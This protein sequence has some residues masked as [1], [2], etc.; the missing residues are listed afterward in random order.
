MDPVRSTVLDLLERGLI[1]VIYG[2]T[3][4]AAHRAGTGLDDPALLLVAASNLVVVVF[5]VL[6]PRPGRISE[7]P[8]D[9]LIAVIGTT[10]PMFAVP[11]AGPALLPVLA[12]MTLTVLG[13]GVSFA[14]KLTLRRNFSIV[15]ART[16]IVA[17]GV[18]RLVRHPMYSGYLLLQLGILTFGFEPRNLVCFAVCWWMLW[19]RMGREEAVLAEDERY[20]A[21]RRRVRAR[22]LPGLV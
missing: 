5:V 1:L 20:L 7:R 18:Y 2:Y 15:P 12:S 19:L 6:R 11:A 4:L 9:W 17:R 14:A 21:Y 3:L 8:L 10:A 16:D 22:V 13:F